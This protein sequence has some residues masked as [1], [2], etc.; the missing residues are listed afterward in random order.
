MKG[1][2]G[3]K[4][5]IQILGRPRNVVQPLNFKKEKHPMCER[6]LATNAVVKRAVQTLIADKNYFTAVTIRN[7]IPKHD[8]STLPQI[9]NALSKLFSTGQ[10]GLGYSCIIVFNNG[11]KAFKLYRFE[12]AD[13]ELNDSLFDQLNSSNFRTPSNVVVETE[14]EDLGD[15]SAEDISDEDQALS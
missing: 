3:T 14:D 9:G 2:S 13:L 10:M 7:I 1:M 4:I 6:T 5:K 11:R 12:N 15:D 8:R